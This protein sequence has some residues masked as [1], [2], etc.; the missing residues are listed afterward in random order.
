[1][2][3]KE[4]HDKTAPAANVANTIQKTRHA[5]TRN[6]NDNNLWGVRKP[7]STAEKE[8][9]WAYDARLFAIRKRNEARRR[10]GGDR[11]QPLIKT[12]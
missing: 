6:Y 8:L 1:M 4:R 5:M 11:N 12:A 7:S 9:S 2:L 10:R 3:Q